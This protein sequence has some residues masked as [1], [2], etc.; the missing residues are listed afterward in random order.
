MSRIVAGRWRG[1]R[2]AVPRSGT[3][4][5][6][7]RVREA[8]FNTLAHQLGGLDAR[9]VLDLYAGS[10]ALGLEAL[11]RGADRALLVERDR[12]AA[13]VIRRNVA[14][15]GARNAAVRVAAVG[16]L[17]RG[18]APT[19]AFDLVLADPPYDVPAGSVADALADLAEAGWL[20]PAAVL[21]VET[22]T[23][24]AGSPW[25][26]GIIASAQRDYGDTRIWYGQREP[27]N[28]GA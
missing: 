11:S 15:L 14:E 21:V 19:V 18:A 1:R 25:P 10:G 16:Q 24:A 8:V 26:A 28:R 27:E 5:T 17:A 4:P 13:A 9:V 22:S 2:L 20:A 7:E 23:R 6:S 3:R 12:A